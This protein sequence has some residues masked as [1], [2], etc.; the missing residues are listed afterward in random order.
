M[1]IREVGF[2]GTVDIT[3]GGDVLM[4]N[5]KSTDGVRCADTS[6]R[7]GTTAV[8]GTSTVARNKDKRCFT[9]VMTHE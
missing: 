1:K 9:G 5:A 3:P 4:M 6:R 2:N 8:E 7:S